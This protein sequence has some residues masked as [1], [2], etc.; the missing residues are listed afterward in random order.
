M[1]E[2]ELI[3]ANEISKMDN[4]NEKKNTR[5]DTRPKKYENT[6]SSPDLPEKHTSAGERLFLLTLLDTS[7]RN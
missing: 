7:L 5:K 1:F 6:P 2:Q 3:N 4:N